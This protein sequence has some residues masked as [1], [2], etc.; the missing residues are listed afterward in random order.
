M[1]TKLQEYENRK[2]DLIATTGHQE[3]QYVPVM[4]DVISWPIAYQKKKTA[5]LI[6]DADLMIRTFTKT[7]REIYCDC[8]T[9]AG[10][11]YPLVAL[12]ILG[13]KGYFISED[14]VTIQHTQNCTMEAEEYGELIRD[15]ENFILNILP[16][17]K[18]S[19]LNGSDNENYAV[20]KNAIMAFSKHMEA[21]GK[22][23][24]ALQ[25]ELGVVAVCG[26]RTKAACDTMFDRIRGFR[27]TIFDMKRKPDELLT[28]LEHV[29]EVYGNPG[30][31]KLRENGSTVPFPFTACHAVPFIRKSD[32]EKFWWPTYKKVVDPIIAEGGRIFMK[33]EGRC[34]HILDVLKDCPKSSFIL[35]LDMED[36]PY[37][38][39]EK[40]GDHATIA[41]GITT[42]QL[43]CLSKQECLDIAKKAIDTFAPGGGFIFTTDKTLISENDVNPENLFAVY[44]FAH[45]YGKY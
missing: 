14:E 15:T 36:D 32:F 20:L 39:Y 3:P 37:K 16:K 35:Q 41:C 13:G 29:F 28:A 38:V 42:N 23:S 45:E 44:Q 11:P 6:K 19:N 33:S 10:I 17:R 5:D 1:L 2:A 31:E 40:I 30:L 34:G 26:G 4:L 7:L 27:E 12:N 8:I 25:N 18:F 9:S 24:A 22:L 21:A 43:K